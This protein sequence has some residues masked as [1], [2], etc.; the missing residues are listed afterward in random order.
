MRPTA[1]LI[2]IYTN[3]QTLLAEG[4]FPGKFGAVATESLDLVSSIIAKLEQDSG[5]ETGSD[6][7]SV[8]DAPDAAR[9]AGGE[10]QPVGRKGRKRKGK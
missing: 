2:R 10:V 9:V 3:I 4:M 8:G 5:Q 1:D 6:G 7:S